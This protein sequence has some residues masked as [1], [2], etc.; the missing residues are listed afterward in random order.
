MDICHYAFPKHLDLVIQGID[1]MEAIDNFEG[2]GSFNSEIK[3]YVEQQ[4]L[5]LCD[6]L[7]PNANNNP[8]KNEQIKIWLI[9]S[10]AKTLKEQVRL[11]LSL[12]ELIK[13]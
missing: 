5:M 13:Y 4:F 1:R 8:E 6:N 10:L 9:A 12:P 3:N 11:K 2:C 7:K